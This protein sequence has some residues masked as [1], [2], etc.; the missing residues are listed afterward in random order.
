MVGNEFGELSPSIPDIITQKHCSSFVHTELVPYRQL[1]PYYLEI[2]KNFP[3][4]G[5]ASVLKK[6]ESRLEV[7]TDQSVFEELKILEQTPINPWQQR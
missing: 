2:R 1:A 3:M 4:N 6:L 7:P 5:V